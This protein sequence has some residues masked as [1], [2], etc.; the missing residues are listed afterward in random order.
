MDHAGSSIPPPASILGLTSPHPPVHLALNMPQH[1]LNSDQGGG[2]EILRTAS[3]SSS[4]QHLQFN[5]NNSGGSGISLSTPS[6]SSTAYRPHEC[7][8]CHKRFINTSHLRD[9]LRLHT[10]ERPFKCAT[11]KRTF[12]QRQHLRQHEIRKSCK[13]GVGGS[14]SPRGYLDNN[15]S[16]DAISGHISEDLS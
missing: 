3:S 10:G 14:I 15:I 5:S 13:T 4:H 8:F 7:H 11:C 12:V 2:H 1:L 16:I 6:S 9:H